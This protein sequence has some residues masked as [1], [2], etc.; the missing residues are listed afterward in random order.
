MN[1]KGDDEMFNIIMYIFMFIVSNLGIPIMIGLLIY[2]IWE[3]KHKKKKKQ[4]EKK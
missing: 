4:V 2:L 1:K 3:E